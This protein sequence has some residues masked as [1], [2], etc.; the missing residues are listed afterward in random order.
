MSADS[1]EWLMFILELV[2]IAMIANLVVMTLAAG[3]EVN[4]LPRG[5]RESKLSL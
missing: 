3:A 1:N 4:N 5:N 2:D